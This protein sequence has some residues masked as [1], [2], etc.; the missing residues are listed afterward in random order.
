MVMILVDRKS[1]AGQG[2]SSSYR[3]GN[4]VTV[5]CDRVEPGVMSQVRCH[6]C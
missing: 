4:R 1:A 2:D 6:S 5:I 3:K